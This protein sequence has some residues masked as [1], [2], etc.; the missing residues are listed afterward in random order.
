MI[1]VYREIPNPEKLARWLET[2]I[3]PA[4]TPDVSNYAKGRLRVWLGPEPFLSNPK[5]TKPG[6][7]V[8]EKFLARLEELIE[9][10]FEFCLVT[11]SGDENPIGIDPH[12][13]AGF[14]D[15]EARSVH[16]SGECR[17][18]YWMGRESFGAGPNLKHYTAEDSPTHSLL[19]QPGQVTKFNCKNLHAASPGVRRWNI[20]F[21][22]GKEARS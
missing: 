10:E 5:K 1:E 17:F 8:G 12:R 9:W 19:L 4:L 6:L 11:Y 16:V 3:R 15:F 13:D 18:D 21:W 7:Q 14:A 22:R 20:N 2:T